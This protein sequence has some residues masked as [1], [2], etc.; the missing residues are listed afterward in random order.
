MPRRFAFTRLAPGQQ[1]F[2]NAI[3]ADYVP[4][5]RIGDAGQD[6]SRLPILRIG[7][8]HDSDPAV[9]RAHQFLNIHQLRRIVPGV[10][11]IAVVVVVI[12]DRLAQ[13]T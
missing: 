12:R 4:S 3:V 13:P 2:N 6:L 8:R 9:F 1:P 5:I 10:T 11:G 7:G